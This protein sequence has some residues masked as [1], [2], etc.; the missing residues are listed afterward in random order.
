MIISEIF[1]A[2]DHFDVDEPFVRLKKKNKKVWKP[3]IYRLI[4]HLLE[5]G[6]IQEAPF[7]DGHQRGEH[8]YGHQH[9]CHLRCTEWG[10]T[11][12]FSE[13]SL[14]PIEKRLGGNMVSRSEGTSWR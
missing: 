11:I 9:H 12:P 8:I 4:P 5:A 6:L 10:E 3:S 14:Q 2:H 13:P 1:S 7:G